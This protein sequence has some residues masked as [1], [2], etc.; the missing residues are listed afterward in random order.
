MGKIGQNREARVSKNT[1]K[2]DS[3]ICG[4]SRSFSHL[5]ISRDCNTTS[6]DYDH[7]DL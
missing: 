4:F 3:P 1:K 5:L 6:S 2:F 7:F